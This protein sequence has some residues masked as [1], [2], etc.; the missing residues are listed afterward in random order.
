MIWKK[1][2][3]KKIQF[4]LLSSIPQIEILKLPGIFTQ[5][6]WYI[7]KFEALIYFF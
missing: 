7:Y 4:Y 1:T 2:Y 3:G 5:G 6:P